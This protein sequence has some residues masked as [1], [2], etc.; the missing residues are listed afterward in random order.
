MP[1]RPISI[2]SNERVGGADRQTVLA[3]CLTGRLL[4][5]SGEIGLSG[6]AQRKGNIDQRAIAASQQCFR[7]LEPSGADVAMWRL[8]DGLPEG[9][10]KMVSAE[11]RNGCHSIKT[12]IAF[13]VCLYVVK[14][15]EEPASIE[16]PFCVR[17]T[18]F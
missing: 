16:R 5:C 8:P 11:A 2:R 7:T 6:K 15:T 10:R 17:R 9:P 13:Q 1:A 12:E 4:E 14:N 3:G 18:G